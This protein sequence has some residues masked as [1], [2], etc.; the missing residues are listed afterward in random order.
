MSRTET[1]STAHAREGSPA[2]AGAARGRRECLAVVLVAAAVLLPRLGARSLADWDEAIYAQVAR[3]MLERG[4]FLV[5]HHGGSPFFEK[6]PLYFWFTV[7]CYFVAGVTELG[8]R[9]GSALSGIGV[10]AV[11]ASLGFALGGRWVGTVAPVVLLTSAGFVLSSR[12][13]MLDVPLTLATWLAVVAFLR[14]RSGSPRHAYLVAV[15]AA[16]AVMLKSV[17]GLIAPAGLALAL[18]L[19]PDG[20]DQRRSAALRR[21][22][23]LGLALAAP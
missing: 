10:A 22:A 7:G 12:S 8:A 11:V 6:P 18:W 3:E 23:A 15:A 19:D 1:I 20:R 2:S 17:A 16:A 13:G 5:P 9:L 21:A 14:F 4:D